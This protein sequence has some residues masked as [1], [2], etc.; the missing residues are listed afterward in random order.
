VL[1]GCGEPSVHERKNRREFEAMLTAITL[2]NKKELDKDTRRIEE[3]N[4]S[5]DLSDES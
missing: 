1:V 3:R 4:A 2:K 5:G